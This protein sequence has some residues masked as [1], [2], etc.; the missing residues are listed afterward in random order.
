MAGAAPGFARPPYSS[1]VGAARGGVNRAK[2]G[3]ALKMALEGEAVSPD[4]V[5][6]D[7]HEAHP[8]RGSRSSN[9]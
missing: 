6:G 8:G 7:E 3:L 4:T 5:T 2:G 1:Q 9:K